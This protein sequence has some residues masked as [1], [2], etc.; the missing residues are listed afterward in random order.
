M[1]APL[2]AAGLATAAAHKLA[3]LG[4]GAGLLI[5]G[6]ITADAATGGG[7]HL[8][9]GHTAPP[10]HAVAAVAQNQPDPSG[11]T[12]A[13]RCLQAHTRRTTSSRRRPAR[14]RPLPSN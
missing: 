13:W 4:L 8:G 11:P 9:V 3:A 10:G 2:L 7:L 1:P 5:G 6:T 12:T 14:G